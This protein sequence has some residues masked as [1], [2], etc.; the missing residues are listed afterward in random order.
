[1]AGPAAGAAGVARAP[2]A[3]R[4]LLMPARAAAGGGLKNALC[5]LSAPARAATAGVTAAAATAGRGPRLSSPSEPSVS[6]RRND[7]SLSD[8]SA[9]MAIDAGIGAGA[10]AGAGERRPRAAR[11]SASR[12]P[13]VVKFT[14]AVGAAGAA[15]AAGA[16]TKDVLAAARL[17]AGAR[18]PG[19]LSRDT[20]EAPVEAPEKGCNEPSEPWEPSEAPEGN[21]RPV[22]E[23]VEP[24][25]DEAAG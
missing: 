12:L 11:E 7:E 6:E 13:T 23:P 19:V 21:D 5:P 25:D 24:D 1:V 2:E 17:V 4:V 14:P 8:P 18:T 10:A 3:T 15:N 20:V 22:S 16:P 9:A